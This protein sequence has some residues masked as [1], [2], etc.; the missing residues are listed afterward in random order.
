MKITLQQECYHTVC[1]SF[2][3]RKTSRMSFS[4]ML[5]TSSP[6]MNSRTQSLHLAFVFEPFE[7]VAYAEA[8]TFPPATETSLCIFT[9]LFIPN[10]STRPLTNH[11]TLLLPATPVNGS[12]QCI[13]TTFPNI[14]QPSMFAFY[15]FLFVF[16]SSLC[17]SPV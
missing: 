1:L 16:S 14:C 6:P 9:H 8:E 5:L 15:L 13:V 4:N 11:L 12:L 7:T 17:L 10:L 2:T 3:R